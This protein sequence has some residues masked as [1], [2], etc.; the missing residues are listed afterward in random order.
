MNANNRPASL[1]ESFLE[2]AKK[3]EKQGEE[4]VANQAILFNSIAKYGADLKEVYAQQ[5]KNLAEALIESKALRVDLKEQGE[6][7]RIV[8][9]KL[10]ASEGET[11]PAPEPTIV[12]GLDTPLR[13]AKKT[14]KNT[15][16]MSTPIRMKLTTEAMRESTLGAIGEGMSFFASRVFSSHPNAATGTT[17]Q[18]NTTRMSLSSILSLLSQLM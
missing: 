2:K 3:R 10:I 11:E 15:N 18:T 6:E 12:P 16:F 8:Y 1:A 17:S 14:T 9:L 13:P 5:G 4:L 7:D